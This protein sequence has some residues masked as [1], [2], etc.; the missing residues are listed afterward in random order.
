MWHQESLDGSYLAPSSVP[1]LSGASSPPRDHPSHIPQGHPTAA[2]V[3]DELER[4]LIGGGEDGSFTSPF[5]GGVGLGDLNHPVMPPFMG[6]FPSSSSV[7]GH[8]AVVQETSDFSMPQRREGLSPPSFTSTTRIPEETVVFR[9]STSSSSATS[10]STLSDTSRPGSMIGMLS[11]PVLAEASGSLLLEAI[12][13]TTTTTT[14]MTES[15]SLIA[16][17]SIPE[18]HRPMFIN[19]LSNPPDLSLKIKKKAV[20]FNQV[21]MESNTPVSSTKALRR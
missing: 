20:R 3:D 6:S 15:E 7:L 4:R 13:P 5:S 1:F 14:T 11:S 12:D 10:N 8:T 2:H 17:I 19:V 21:V 16:R 9:S 18:S